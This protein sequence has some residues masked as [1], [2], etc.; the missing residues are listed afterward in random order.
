MTY[1]A[2]PPWKSD[3]TAKA[4]EAVLRQIFKDA[5]PLASTKSK[6]GLR[7][8]RSGLTFQSEY[9][10]TLAATLWSYLK[11]LL[12]QNGRSEKDQVTWSP[13]FS[14]SYRDGAPMIT[15]GAGLLNRADHALVNDS[16]ILTRSAHLLG[17]TIFHISIPPLRSR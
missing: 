7:Q 16:E 2:R 13:L 14:F 1:D 6:G 10:S 15:L 12:I 5:V 17:E 4:R 8:S 3:D 9:G 11:N